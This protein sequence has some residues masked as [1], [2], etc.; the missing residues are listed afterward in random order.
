MKFICREC[1]KEYEAEV[2]NH[3]WNLECICGGLAIKE[4]YNVEG[5]S[6]EDIIALGKRRAENARK[7]IVAHQMASE[8]RVKENAEDPKI[9]ISE[10]T[11]GY[12]PKYPGGRGPVTVPTS[13]VESIKEKG[14]KE[15]EKV[16]GQKM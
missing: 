10:P 5:A 16:T 15:L 7:S 1:K 2:P 14:K 4:G 12:G 11:K 6:T 3:I 9:T 13:V 8:A